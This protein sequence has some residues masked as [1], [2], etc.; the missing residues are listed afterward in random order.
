MDKSQT[1]RAFDELAE[2]EAS[3]GGDQFDII[4]NLTRHYIEVYG[5]DEHISRR[6]DDYLDLRFGRK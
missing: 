2:L 5:Q 1:L 6:I 3:N 4:E